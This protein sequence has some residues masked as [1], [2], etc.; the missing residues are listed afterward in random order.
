MQSLSPIDSNHAIP[1]SEPKTLPSI[2]DTPLRGAELRAKMRISHHE[3]RQ[4]VLATH[5]DIVPRTQAHNRKCT[6]SS[7]EDEKV[8]RSDVVAAQIRA[9]RSMLPQLIKRFSRLPDYRKASTVKHKTTV[10]MMF[11]LFAFIFRLSSR[12][13]MNRELSGAMIF[14][15]MKRIFPELDSI[16]HADTLVRLPERTDSKKIEKIYISLIRDLIKK[17]KILKVIDTRLS[18]YHN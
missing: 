17:K 15:H 6:Y 3:I 5:A 9:W 1:A 8:F 7:L 11:G 2:F 16:P 13:E 14:E 4:K 10:L 18:S 12:R